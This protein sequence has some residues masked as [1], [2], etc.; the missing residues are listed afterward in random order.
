MTAQNFKI[1]PSSFASL[2]IVASSQL[3]KIAPTFGKPGLKYAYQRNKISKSIYSNSKI[4]L[5]EKPI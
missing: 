1:T 2:L 3:T 5:S 4:Y